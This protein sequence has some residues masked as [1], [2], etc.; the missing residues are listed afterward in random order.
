MKHTK[1]H[2]SNLII[3]IL[4]IILGVATLSQPAANLLSLSILFGFGAF[5]KG[6]I[7]LYEASVY[8]KV[9]GHH[10]GSMILVGI[11]DIIIGIIL[12][13]QLNITAATLPYVFSIWMIVDSVLSL[14]RYDVLD[15]V[16]TGHYVLS[17]IVSI[18]G[19]ALGI[20]LFLNPVIAALSLAILISLYFLMFGCFN[21]Y[22]AFTQHRYL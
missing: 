6:F 8:R 12:L 22:L 16:S 7:D 15:S 5:I 18:L 14:F 20:L 4:L 17:I 13:M 9:T 10:L 3:G 11:L 19:I 1:I 21:I 2:W